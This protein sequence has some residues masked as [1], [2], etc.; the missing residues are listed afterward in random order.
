MMTATAAQSSDGLMA[1]EMTPPPDHA[2]VRP[3]ATRAETTPSGPGSSSSGPGPADPV[4]IGSLIRAVAL[5]CVLCAVLVACAL[6]LVGRADWWRGFAAATVVTVMATVAS[7]P[8]IAWSLRVGA[9]RADLA[10]AAFF[11]A[12]AVRAGVSLGAALVAVRAGDYPKAPTL[13]LVVPYYFALLAAETFVLVRVLWTSTGAAA[14]PQAT[15]AQDPLT[16]ENHA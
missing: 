12:A 11:V 4:S 3:L 13:L 16:R 10:T 5:A 6:T 14:K 9:Q 1:A 15:S 2:P 8:I 7:V